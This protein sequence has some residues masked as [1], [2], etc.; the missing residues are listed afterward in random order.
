MF[1]F[2]TKNTFERR[3]LVLYHTATAAN[4][5]EHKE[6]LIKSLRGFCGRVPTSVKKKKL[7]VD[8]IEWSLFSQAIFCYL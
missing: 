8:V 5:K 3:S 7:A 2:Q 4:K 6:K 1:E